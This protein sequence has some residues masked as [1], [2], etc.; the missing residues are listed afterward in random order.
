VK[1]YCQKKDCK[2]S[3]DNAVPPVDNGR[4]YSW[5]DTCVRDHMPHLEAWQFR[6]FANAVSAAAVGQCKLNRIHLDPY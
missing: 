4:R 6:L 5:L 1:L 2:T 3:R